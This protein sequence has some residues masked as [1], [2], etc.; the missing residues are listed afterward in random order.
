MQVKNA[1]P[2]AHL[3]I[4]HSA[5]TCNS[6]A[7]Q[8]PGYKVICAQTRWHQETTSFHMLLCRYQKALTQT[9]NPAPAVHLQNAHSAATLQLN[10]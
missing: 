6:T 7:E 9:K 4:A 3:Q 8:S 5:A 10:S 2:A 1:A